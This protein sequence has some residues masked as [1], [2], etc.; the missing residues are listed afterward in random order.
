MPGCAFVKF[1]D[2]IN[3]TT[4]SSGRRSLAYRPFVGLTVTNFGGNY[5]RASDFSLHIY[6]VEL[7]DDGT[8]QCQASPTNDGQPALRS[9]FAKLSVLVPP[10]KPK[11]LQGDFLVT[12]EDRELVI[13]CISSAG[14]PPAEAMIPITQR[15]RKDAA[16]LAARRSH[17]DNKQQELSHEITWIDGLG[18]VLRHGIK[19]T[20]EAYDNGPLITVKSVLRVM[21]RKDHDNTTFTCQ[22]QNMADRS[23]QSAKLRVE[24][25]YAPKVSLSKIDRIVEGSELRFKCCAE[26]N[27]PDV[28]YRWFINKKK[29]IGDY[30]TEMIIHNATR[31][32]HD[33]TVKCEVSNEVGKSEESQTMDIRYGPQFRHPPLSV[34]THYGATEILQC[35]V[36]GNPMPEIE[37]YHEDSDRMVANSPN[38]SVVVSSD[39]A[40]RYYCKARVRGF[41]ELTG[42]AN[43]YI[44][45]PPSIVSQRIQYVPDEGVVKVKCTAISVPKAESVVWS[46]AGRE[47]NFTS[48]NTPFYVQEEYAA[49]RVVSTVT[50]LDPISTYFGDY[51]C[52]VTNSFGTDSVI[53]KLTAHTLIPVDWQLILIIAGLVVC[54]IL[55]GIIV[56]LILQCRD[57]IKQPRPRTAQNQETDLQETDSNADRYR[58]SDRSSNLSDVKADIR[59]GS[60]VSNAESVTALDSEGEGSTRGVNALALAGPVPNPLSGYRY[61]ADYTEPSF[62]PKN[63]DGSNNNG[64]VPYVDYTRDYMPP[65]T[66]SMGAS[67]ESLSRISTSGILSSKKIG[68]SSANLGSSTPQTTPI[69]PRFSATYGNPYLR[70]SAAEQL[71]HA[72]HTAVPG[73]TPAPPPYTQAMRMNSLNTLNGAGPQDTAFL[74]VLQAPLSAHYITGGPNGA[75]ATVKRTSAVGT[76]ATHTSRY[77][78]GPRPAT[79]RSTTRDA[80]RL[81][82]ASEQSQCRYNQTRHA[83]DTERYRAECERLVGRR[84]QGSWGSR[85]HGGVTD[86]AQRMAENG[87]ALKHIE[88]VLRQ[89]QRA[90]RDH[91]QLVRQRHSDVQYEIGKRINERIWHHR[92]HHHYRDGRESSI[93]ASRTWSRSSSSPWES[94]VTL[95]KTQPNVTTRLLTKS[96]DYGGTAQSTINILKPV[97]GRVR[98]E[99]ADTYQ[100]MKYVSE[101]VGWIDAR[102]T[103][104]AWSLPGGTSSSND[105]R[106]SSTV[107]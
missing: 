96:R 79:L 12:T 69:D 103:L 2:A 62:P 78:L 30:T 68:L 85:G 9:R 32:L 31:E 24:V 44:R 63:N 28:E 16:A 27:P 66:Q 10:Q 72:P 56:I 71:R 97:S 93:D 50:L 18:N 37:W 8:Y 46:F 3:V 87:E 20:K 102:E 43:I 74:F 75:M 84:S 29:V 54:V 34:E 60:S 22:S 40:G 13:E 47:L 80:R 11:I 83:H 94:D 39:T 36:D 55:I 104:G 65:T 76:L 77:S 23:P 99:T 64:Y 26:A 53:I 91:Q 6:P 107:V 86:R 7:E 21:P 95:R 45:A 98:D 92:Y 67:R 81:V 49:E 25:R 4:G 1:T 73:V 33:A 105:R 17:I 59:A 51:N 48:N 70:M 19:T 82:D 35:D 106:T 5:G 61:S 88:L 90:S 41:P 58:E 15:T 42:H 89:L 101:S 100:E 57:R 38:I 14:K 52:T